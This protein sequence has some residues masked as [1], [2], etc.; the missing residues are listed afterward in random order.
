MPEQTQSILIATLGG[1]PQVITFALDA[2]LDRGEP[3]HEVYVLSLNGNRERT[4]QAWQRLQ[5][6]FIDDYYRGRRCRLRRVPITH[7]GIEL[8][9]IRSEADVNTVF[10]AIRDLIVSLKNQG[11]RLH[12]CL[13][14]GRRMVAML[15][16]S[17]AILFC[18]HH[19][20]IW[21]MYTPEDTLER[22]K[23]GVIMHLTPADGF[24]L[25][26]VPITPWGAYLPALRSLADPATIRQRLPGL[27]ASD[28]LRCRQVWERLSA[29]QREVLSAFACGLRPD[30][31]AERFCI[32]LST[33]NTHKTAILK[34][35]RLVWELD[36]TA[37]IDYRFLREHFA[38]FVEQVYPANPSL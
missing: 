22:V 17:V 10:T 4:R 5:Q 34:E 31:V 33:V 6:E 35:C 30:Q 38:A 16:I 13:S 1:Q 15:A 12:L 14:G 7:G 19:D 27:I 9:D 20:Q 23:D 28:E 37:P 11:R 21:H 8:D 29:R 36:E 25:L 32:S 2:L 26:R 3:I 24:R 18:D